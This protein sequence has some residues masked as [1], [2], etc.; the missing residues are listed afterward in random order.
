MALFPFRASLNASTLFPYELGIREQIRIA[1]EAGYDGIEIWMKDLR[2]Y[3]E[4]G[5]SPRELGEYAAELGIEISNAISFIPWADDDAGVRLKGVG[6]ADEELALLA[7]LGC[8]SFAA[9]PFGSVDRATLDDVAERYAGLAEQC[10]SFG[11]VPILEFWG[12]AKKLSRLSEAVYVAMQSRVRDVSVLLDPFHMYTGGSSLEDLTYLSA[13][14]IGIVHANDYPDRPPRET[15][16]DADR[17]FPGDGI[18][19]S[20]EF[21]AKLASAGYRGFMSLELFRPHYGGRSALET[22]KHGL[23]KL[24]NAYAV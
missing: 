1:A 21:A 22:A 17:L 14:R 8:P 10:R 5:G 9:P 2:Q 13:E 4:D 19:P 12:R 3:A 18:A 6:Q 23:V 11:V 15:I 20:A 24:K 16:G 7:E